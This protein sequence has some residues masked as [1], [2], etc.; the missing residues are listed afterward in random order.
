[1]RFID[2][3]STIAEIKEAIER[4][5]PGERA[6][7]EAMVWPDWDRAEGDNPPCVREK[8]AEAA[9]GRFHR[10]DRSNMKKILS[11]LE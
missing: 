7:L 2:A 11:S 8:L 1:L 10:G 9:K 4:L 5:S 3:V 6:E